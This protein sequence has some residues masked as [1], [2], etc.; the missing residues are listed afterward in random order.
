MSVETT[1]S[2]SETATPVRTAHHRRYLMCTPSHFT[3]NYS[4][5]PWMHPEE[6]TDT[7]KAV[8][9]WQS[10]VDVYEQLGFD[11]SY[12]EPIEGLPDMVYAANGGFV[13]DGV[14]LPVR[15]NI[16]IHTQPISFIGLPVVAVPLPLSPLPIGVQII[17]APWREDVALRVAF[18]LEQQGVAVAPRP[19]QF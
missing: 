18:A 6:P 19:A 7:S 12:I 10:L 15:A 4:I 1:A 2:T 16:G 14:A 11:I 8:E 9:Q 17:A 3:V 13:L 5:N